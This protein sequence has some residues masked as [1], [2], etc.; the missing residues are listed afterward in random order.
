MVYSTMK[1]RLEKSDVLLLDACKI[2]FRLLF[3]WD[4][5]ESSNSYFASS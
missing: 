4:I 1:Y 5:C 2:S 3:L